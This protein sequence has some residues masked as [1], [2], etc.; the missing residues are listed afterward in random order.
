MSEMQSSNSEYGTL[1]LATP[2]HITSFPL[3]WQKKLTVDYYNFLVKMK[4][5]NLKIKKLIQ[6]NDK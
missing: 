1:Y 4:T 3:K 2:R 5:E 6:N